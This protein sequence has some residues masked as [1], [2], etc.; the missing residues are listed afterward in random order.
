MKREKV[1]AYRLCKDLGIDQGQFSKFVH[2][3]TNIS[4][5]KLEQVAEYLGYDLLLVKRK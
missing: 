1:T 4:L 5:E 3:K 2:G